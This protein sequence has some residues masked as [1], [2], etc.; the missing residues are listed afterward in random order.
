MKLTVVIVNYNV[1]HYLYQC[2]SSLNRALQGIEA[3]V[4]VVDNHSKDGS[5]KALQRDFPNVSF[6]ALN[7]NLGFA[8]ANNIAIRQAKGEYVLLLNP[9]TIVGEGVLHDCLDFMQ[10][11]ENAGAVGVKMLSADGAKAME[12]RRGLPTPMTAFYKF[13]GLCRRMPKSKRFGKYYMSYLSWE[14]AQEI[15]VVSGAFCLLSHRALQKAGLL[16]ETFFMYGEDIDLSYRLLKAGFQ[17]F[18]LPAEILHY[19]GESTEKS[20]FRYVHVFYEAMLIFFKKHYGNMALCLSLPI[21]LAIWFNALLAICRIQANKANKSL[22]FFPKSE[23]Q[24]TYYL[25]VKSGSK[26]RAERLLRLK[27][28]TGKVVVA[29]QKSLPDGHLAL[30]EINLQAT[31]TTYF[32]YD[33]AAFQYSTMLRLFA[34]M[35]MANVFLGTYYGEKN[36]IIT[37]KEV[38]SL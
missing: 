14:E 22:G 24:E 12:S 11:H 3:E 21:K 15:E 30:K 1:R 23:P 34:R 19:K 8:K 7:H 18:Y 10:G 9:D 37:P 13:T 16:D 28:L 32:V 17:N 38:L 35:P 20:S 6:I 29:D 4:F 25:L 31:Q 27:G 2:L 36:M 26:D 33:T 5:V